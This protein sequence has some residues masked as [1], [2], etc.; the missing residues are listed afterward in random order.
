MDFIFRRNI[1]TILEGNYLLLKSPKCYITKSFETCQIL[2]YH[3]VGVGIMVA[4]IPLHRSGRAGL[5]H[6]APASGDSAKSPQGIVMTY[7]GLGQVSVD[8]PV[9]SFPRDPASLPASRQRSAPQPPHSVAEQP[10]R[11]GVHGHPVVSVIPRK[12]RGQPTLQLRDRPAHAPPQFNLDLGQLGLQPLSHGLAIH[13][14]VPVASLFH[15]LLPA[16]LTGAFKEKKYVKA[17]LFL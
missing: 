7:A 17:L 11:L 10:L 13:R 16:G 1:N 12:Q 4:Q 9:R 8:E 2:W 15:S 5:P 3:V 6:T 14:K